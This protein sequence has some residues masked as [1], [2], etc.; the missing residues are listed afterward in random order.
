MLRCAAMDR[1]AIAADTLRVINTGRYVAPSGRE[2]TVADAIDAA[3]K[4]SRCYSPEEAARLVTALPVTQGTASVTV[5][6]EST[7]AAARRLFESGRLD[8][9]ALN[10]ASAKNAGGG[11]LNGARAQE[12]DLARCS[13]L[14]PCLMSQPKFYAANRSNESML[15]LDYAIVSPRVP[16]FRDEQ[17]AMLESPFLCAVVTSPA[18]NA[19][20]ALSREPGCAADLDATL[21][22]RARQV[23][24]LF[25]TH[26]WKTAVLGAWGCGVF[27]NSPDQVAG[28]FRELLAEPPFRGA[29]TEVV[30]AV[31]DKSKGQETLRAFERAL[32]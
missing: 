5:T 2:V 11:F 23:L 30:F 12:E 24:A 18:P 32:G 21:R 9:G 25:V 17:G 26:G 29:F 1:K 13:A 7:G 14:Y 27:R 20:Q 28:I 31:Y 15:Y 3:V 8:V 6:D 4:G 19:G 16:F 10:F 22:R